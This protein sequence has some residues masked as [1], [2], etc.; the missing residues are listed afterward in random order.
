MIVNVNLSIINLIV[1][2]LCFIFYLF[3]G[4]NSKKN[5]AENWYLIIF[6]IL[7]LIFFLIENENKI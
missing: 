3:F 7:N 6:G 1:G 4:F 5:W 2:V